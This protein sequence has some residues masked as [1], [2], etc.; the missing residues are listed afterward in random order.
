MCFLQGLGLPCV[1]VHAGNVLLDGNGHCRLSEFELGLLCAPTAAELL[2][3]PFRNDAPDGPRSAGSGPAELKPSERPGQPSEEPSG[4]QAAEAVEA[5][6]A[7][8][9]EAEAAEAAEAAEVE[10]A[11][12]AEAAEGH[13]AAVGASAGPGL[14]V[15]LAGSWGVGGDV[16]AF[17]HLLFELLTGRELSDRELER[18]RAALR[19]DHCATAAPPCTA[20]PAAWHV[21]RR[22]FVP[23]ISAQISAQI[24]A[25]EHQATK[26]TAAPYVP[27]RGALPQLIA[28]DL[29]Q[30]MRR[31]RG[32]EAAGPTVATLLQEPTTTVVHSIVRSA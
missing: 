19:A 2:A 25:R 26:P 11:E 30:Q 29:P 31:S 18:W 28:L 8:A 7:E 21:L 24:S 3:R 14:D 23:E 17:G 9:V 13:H 20:A 15:R 1:H 27:Y 4:E 22:I 10:A 12:E 16:V 5:E 6:A 32:R